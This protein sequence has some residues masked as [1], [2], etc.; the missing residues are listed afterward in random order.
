MTLNEWTKKWVA[1]ALICLLAFLACILYLFADQF[2]NDNEANPAYVINQARILVSDS[3]AYLEQYHDDIDVTALQEICAK[4]D[5]NLL[6]IQLDGNVLFNS[7]ADKSIQKVDV[8]KSLHYDLYTAKTEKKFFKIT[9][10]VVDDQTQI[11]IGNAIFLLPK[12]AVGMGN[13]KVIPLIPIYL[14]IL[15]SILFCSLLYILRQKMKKNI[16]QPIKKLSYYS[17]AIL[18]GDYEQKAEYG[19]TDEMGEVYAVFDQ[20]RMEIMNLSKRRDA[21]EKAQKELIT[22]ISH[23]IKTPLTTVKAYLDA[24]RDGVCPDM[25]SVMDYIEVMRSNTDK[26]TR[27]L[28]DLLLHALQE[29]GQ[30][31]VN[32][33]E[34]YSKSML[35]DMIKPIGHYVRTTGVVFIE[36]TEIPDVLIAADAN[37]LEQVISNLITNALKHTSPGDSIRIQIVQELEQLKITIADT[38]V[39]ILPQDMPFIFGRYFKGQV[40]AKNEGNGLGLSICKHIIEAHNGSISFKSKKGEGTVFIFTIPLC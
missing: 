14:I 18:K 28:E 11:Q 3:L 10:P 12:S 8:K 34:Q 39:G 40:N 30:I 27:L 26:M 37:R 36:P 22:T 38:G 23:E 20:M 4:N 9:F 32:P 2:L 19:R 21:Q 16:I 33:I 13:T 5:L 25:E 31:S 17:E 7:S 6:L 15:F 29:L 24:I 35:L 1:A